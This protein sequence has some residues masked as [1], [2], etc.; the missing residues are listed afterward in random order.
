MRWFRERKEKE[1]DREYLVRRE[2]LLSEIEQSKQGCRNHDALQALA[3]NLS[4]LSNNR[5][6]PHDLLVVQKVEAEL[7]L[8]KPVALLFPTTLRLRSRFYRFDPDR[9]ATWEADLKRLLPDASTVKEEDVLRQRLRHLTYELNEEAEG[10]NRRSLQK[11]RVVRN[12]TIAGII[13]LFLLLFCE[14]RAVPKQLSNSFDQWLIPGL[15]AGALGS[16]TSAIVAIAD[17]TARKE[18]FFWTL[19]V[20]LVVRTTL[21]AV[22]AFM[23]LA[24]VSSQL[25]PLAPSKPEILLPFVLA[26]SFVAGFSDKLFGQTVSQL[27]TRSSDSPPRAQ[28]A[29][30]TRGRGS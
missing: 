13:L 20:Q 25:V 10:Y 15:L 8:V 27:I 11:S 1:A 30:S 6:D 26:L 19:V 17:E 12:L 7:C 22:Y 4:A 23:V 28:R 24:A 5:P 18:E 16:N 14:I 2:R 9:R 29:G 3:Q 21:G